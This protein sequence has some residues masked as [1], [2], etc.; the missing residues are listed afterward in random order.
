MGFIQNLIGKF[1]YK[2]DR[3][4]ELELE[5]DAQERVLEKKKSANERELERYDD[6]ARE[7]MIENRLK[8]ERAKRQKAIW[9]T[10]LMKT[11]SRCF[12]DNTLMKE[13]NNFLMGGNRR[14]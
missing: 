2:S 1:K 14:W 9:K 12:I 13:R 11:N 4:K 3:E 8:W 10:T 7:K 5:I 6:E